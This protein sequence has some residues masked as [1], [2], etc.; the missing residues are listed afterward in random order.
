MN[1][2]KVTKKKKN[3][4]RTEVYVENNEIMI[5]SHTYSMRR[6][7]RYSK[8]NRCFKSLSNIQYPF[9]CYFC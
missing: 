5:I 8:F 6:K 3:G 1:T 9:P 4:N 2:Q 7:L